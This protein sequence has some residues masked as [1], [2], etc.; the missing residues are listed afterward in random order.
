MFV[1]GIDVGTQG[2]RVVACDPQGVVQAQAAEPFA[3]MTLPDLPP[4][5]AEQEPEMWWA[6]VT[7]CLR[8]VLADLRR[9]GQPAEAIS[10]LAV[11]STS[12]TILPIDAKGK[13]LRP[14][15]M[16]NDGRAQVEAEEVQAAG[17]ELAA[18]L[19]YRFNASFALAK[20]LW[21][22]RHEAALFERS[23]RFIHAADFIVGRL[24]GEYG[25]TNFSDALKTGYDVQH[26]RWPDFIETKLAIPLERLPAV[27]RPGAV[28]AHISP[29]CAEATGLPPGIPVLAGMTDGCTSQISTGA[30]APGDWNSTLGTTLVVKGVTEQLLRDPNGRIYSHR[31]PAGY[32]LPG[33]ASNTGGE[34]IALR[35]PQ[36]KWAEFNAQ[37]LEIAPTDTVIYPLARLGERFPFA[38]SAAEGFVLDLPSGAISPYPLPPNGGRVP[39]SSHLRLLASDYTAHLEGV[40]YVERLAYEVLASLGAEIGDTLYNAGGATRSRAWNQ[41]RAD[42][43]GRTLVRPEV[44]GGAMGAAIIAAAGTW[45]DGLIPAA[46]AMVRLMERVEPRPFLAEA[47]ETRYQRFK[48][49]CTARGYLE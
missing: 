21:L 24:T 11:T 17:S 29:G 48:E 4:R 7:T 39:A 44:S 25:V 41:L 37:A 15:M 13:P 30:V 8:R 18:A 22:R 46:R 10:A 31:H 5:W 16:Y 28:I 36:E 1:I 9:R 33:G 42:I 47:Y 43:L 35:F 40:A 34:A 45:Y 6:A 27:A 23:H 14:A 2:A 38:R 3:L 12:G 20:I 49:V 19:G 26:E 32:W